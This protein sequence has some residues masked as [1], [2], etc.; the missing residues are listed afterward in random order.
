[1]Q[2][3][4]QEIAELLLLHAP[5]SENFINQPFC[6]LVKHSQYK[7]HWE[8]IHRSQRKKTWSEEEKKRLWKLCQSLTYEDDEYRLKYYILVFKSRVVEHVLSS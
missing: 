7:V 4:L 1:M 5:C 3:A 8:T 2:G 6:Q